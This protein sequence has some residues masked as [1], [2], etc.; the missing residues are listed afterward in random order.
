M[1]DRRGR[2]EVDDQAV[3]GRVAEYLVDAEEQG[4]PRSPRAAILRALGQREDNDTQLRRLQRK[5][6]QRGE[7]L[8]AAE[9]ERRARR[10]AEAQG[11]LPPNYGALGLREVMKRVQDDMLRVTRLQKEAMRIQD[12]I[13]NLP[14]PPDALA[15]ASR[16]VDEIGGAPITED[17]MLRLARASEQM[18]RLF[19]KDGMEK[20]AERYEQAVRN[21]PLARRGGTPS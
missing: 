17:A 6:K 1:A 13:A 19:E 18:Q 4:R 2:P 8:L 12:F 11:T 21:A 15:R 16:V 5:W 14:Q 20:L 10:H 7:V 3:M 9:R